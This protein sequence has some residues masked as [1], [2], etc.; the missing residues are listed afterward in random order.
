MFASNNRA[1]FHLWWKE[2][3]VKH[4]RVSKYYAIDRSSGSQLFLTTAEI[5]C[6][7]WNIHELH[8]QVTSIINCH[9]S[10][11]RSTMVNFKQTHTIC[12]KGFCIYICLFHSLPILQLIIMSSF[13]SCNRKNKIL[14]WYA[15]TYLEPCQTFT[16][17]FF[18]ENGQQFPYK[19][20]HRCF[21][22]L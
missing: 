7:L 19:L 2:S 8:D 13:S 15:E 20:H 9:F 11:R 5:F 17:E 22:E 18:C 3:L 21:T 10:P 6:G 16:K 4:K 1:S 14:I 12:G